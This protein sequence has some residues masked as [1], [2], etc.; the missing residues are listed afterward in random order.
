MILAYGRFRSCI[1]S[2][3]A[4]SIPILATSTTPSLDPLFSAIL[5]LAATA[6]VSLIVSSLDAL[7]ILELEAIVVLNVTC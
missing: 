3:I 5:P 1:S 7:E 6:L 2:I 4:L